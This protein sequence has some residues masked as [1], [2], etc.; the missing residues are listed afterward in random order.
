MSFKYNVLRR[1]C[2][3]KL[4]LLDPPFP[5][6]AARAW[7]NKTFKPPSGAPWVRETV[8]PV[9]ERLL[10]HTLVQV[11][12]LIQYDLFVPAGSGT[13]SLG[14]LVAM[15]VDTFPPASSVVD[16]TEKL[17]AWIDRCSPGV[18][19]KDVTGVWWM[20]PTV[21]TVRSWWSKE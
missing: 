1:A 8:L 11:I 10:T 12:V 15:I 20:Q 17:S 21:L 4:A 7:E 9:N 3:S 14:E 5:G 13:E 2:R 6:R 18:P 16:N 19:V